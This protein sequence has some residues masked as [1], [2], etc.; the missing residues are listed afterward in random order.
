MKIGRKIRNAR[1]DKDLTQV[2]IAQQIPMNQSSYSKIER[3]LLEPSI[4][5]LRQIC[6]IL[7]LDANNLLEIKTNE[8]KDILFAERVKKD[9]KEI[10]EEK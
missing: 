3:D 1:E 4:E 2:Q 8:N 7:N 10:Y 6:T 9:Y 5:Q